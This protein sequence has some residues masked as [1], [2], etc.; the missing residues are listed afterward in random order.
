MALAVA[1]LPTALV[2]FILLSRRGE[3]WSD[4]I[5]RGCVLFGVAVV[6][7]SEAL[8]ALGA[9]RPV[10]VLIAW[11]AGAAAAA[12]VAWRSHIKRDTGRFSWLDRTLILLTAAM[13]APV[14]FAAWLSPPNSSDAMA[15]HL[16]RVVYWAQQG[17][18]DLF[19]AHYLQQLISP[20]LA[21]YFMLHTWLL[22]GGDRF[23]NFVQFFGFAASVPGAA[24]IARALGAG[25]RGQVLAAVLTA[26][27]P[28]GICQASGTKNDCLMTLWLVLMAYFAI[29]YMQARRKSDLMSAGASLGLALLT[30][31]TTYVIAAPVLL[32]I[33]LAFRKES[34]RRLFAAGAVLAACALT[35]NAPHYLRNYTLSGSPL[36]YDSAHGWASQYQPQF[37]WAN[38]RFGLQTTASNLL[39]NISEHLGARSEA[40]NQAVYRTVIRAHQLL[41]ADP[42]DPATTWLD[43]TY[44]APVN[45][46]HET[47]APNR[48]HLAL[49]ALT[50]FPLAWLA[51]KKRRSDWIW[52]YSGV[53]VS[54]VA[55]CAVFRWQQFF[56]RMHLPMF[57]LGLVAAAL[58][59]ER[60]APPIL[61]VALCLFFLNNARP[62]VFENWIR[63]LEG[64][65]SL[66]RTSREDNYFSDVLSLHPE[67]RTEYRE[68]AAL[69]LRSGCGEV[70][71]DNNQFTL[72]YPLQHLL[73]EGNPR[74]R[75][76]HAGVTNDSERFGKQTPPCAVV[77]LSCSGLP[78]KTRL[79]GTGRREVRVNRSLVFLPPD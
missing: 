36:G 70:G 18:V 10:A 12:A 46:N 21:E 19:A 2:I 27:L 29:R 5:A 6:V 20:P 23:I 28:N 26:T 7:L 49:L 79:H 41:G 11:L 77:C 47:N 40:W 74:I 1:I 73:L 54:F 50:A 44:S 64:S 22:S 78:E 53:I 71:I 72:E 65:R 61:Q 68:A 9:L 8:G 30:K 45:A 59:V 69:V 25:T 31:G 43:T 16:P 35:V 4:A 51:W 32:G 3:G 17:S 57:V 66:L 34:W 67:A 13:L 14:T 55:F 58:W 24:A 42:N 48:W 38:D 52:Y 63:P 39:R 33:V 56:I 76:S 15:Y 62:Y 37:R 60:L 75:F